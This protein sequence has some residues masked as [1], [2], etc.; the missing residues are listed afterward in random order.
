MS[1]LEIKKEL[2]NNQAAILIL[3]S[4]NY[5]DVIVDVA[6]QLS[7]KKTC[8]VTFNKTYDALKELL[9]VN[10][11]DTKN[12]VFIDG[13]TKNV[14]DSADRDDCRFIDSTIAVTELTKNISELLKHDFH[15]LVFDSLTNLFI[16]RGGGAVEYFIQTLVNNILT[17]RNCRGVFFA[18]KESKAYVYNPLMEIKQPDA[19]QQVKNPLLDWSDVFTSRLSD[20]MTI[21]DMGS[22]GSK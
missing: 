8:Y 18:L 14:K 16:Y 5:N 1:K 20:G 7:D 13:I 4:V 15:Y 10:N 17:E 9:K 19:S 11:V 3:H 2:D 6:K 22:N 12:I 21:I